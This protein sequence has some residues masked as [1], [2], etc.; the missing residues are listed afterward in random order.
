MY[1][2]YSVLTDTTWFTC[3]GGF[4]AIRSEQE[5][6][7]QAVSWSGSEDIEHEYAW[8]VSRWDSVVVVRCFHPVPAWRRSDG[9]VTLD[10]HQSVPSGTLDGVRC[11]SCIGC[12]MTRAR[13]WTL[14][15]R[16]ELSEHDE[17]CWCTLT[18]DDG[19]VP[20]TLSKRDCQLYLKR[21][22]KRV[23][24]FRY[25]L[26][27]EYGERTF[28]PHYHA[29]LFGVSVLDR[30]VATEWRHGFARSDR[31]NPACI[32]YVCGYVSKKIGE[33]EAKCERVSVDGEVYVYQPPFLLCSRRPGIGGGARR[34]WPSWK[35]TAVLDGAEISVP[36]YLRESWKT[37]AG[38]KAVAVW[39][40]EMSKLSAQFR[41]S[42]D[43]RED[44]EQV[45]VARRARTAEARSL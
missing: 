45:A 44:S 42:P 27:G 5:A 35:T 16:L 36:R 21:L 23:G 29:L 39:Q 40:R 9:G 33:R 3:C 25:L 43:E 1:L 26:C 2:D 10:V 13:D 20:V 4:Y 17:S 15:A 19:H 6:K 37:N 11:G 7:C 18:Y 22:R 34:F 38:E 8:G 12:R 28:R 14:R 41:L 24:R 32:A 31:L 30:A